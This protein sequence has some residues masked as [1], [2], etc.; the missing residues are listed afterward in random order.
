MKQIYQ[1]IVVGAGH[2][3]CEAALAL[4]RR[5]LSTLIFTL[6]LDNIALMSCNPAI[7]GTAKGHLVKEI[8]ALGGEMGKAADRTGIHFKVLNQSRGP[9]V[10]S[11]RAQCDRQLYRLDLKK[12]LEQEPHLA[13]RQGEVVEILTQGNQV[14][15]VSDHLGLVYEAPVVIL[16]TG[17]FLKG[18]IHVG[19]RSY[20][21]GR[22]GEFA[23]NSLSES[24][25]DLGFQLGRLKT[26][27]P[28]RLRRSTIDF[29]GTQEQRGDDPPRPFSYFTRE[30]TLPQVPCYLTYTN[31]KTHKIIRDNLHLSSLYGGRIKSRGARYCPSIEDKVVRFAEKERHPII[32]E[33]D[34]LET[35][36][37]YANGT[38]NSLPPE[39]QYELI[40]TIPGLEAAEIMRPAY[41]IEYDFIYPTQLLPTLES[42]PI[43]GLFAAGQI[44]GTSGY[45]EAAAQGL[46]A[47]INAGQKLLGLPPFILDRSQ[48][49]MAVLVD[50]LVTKGTAEPYRIFTSRA[51]YRL[52]LREDNAPYR[53]MELGHQLGLIPQ[54]G[55]RQMQEEQRK[56]QQEIQRLE[57]TFIKPT[58]ELNQKMREKGT[59]ELKE[60]ESLGQ[61]LRRPQLGYADIISLSPPPRELSAK[62]L[63]QV[64]IEVKYEGY[65]KRQQEEVERFRRLEEQTLPQDLDYTLIP[66]LSLEVRQK[67]NT[68]KPLSLG[69]AS[70]I[71]GITPAAVSVLMVYLKKTI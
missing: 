6:N 10:Q 65:I 33:P 41:A 30:I 7:G 63:Q 24:L 62:V 9:A 38:G 32:L 57:K 5:G 44:N 60:A 71:S 15:G 4:A 20:P 61:L 58:E 23:A 52:L 55:Y 1:V 50:D 70:R 36:E 49:Y 35:E 2:A 56:I 69:Q 42:K 68:F 19:D 39:V 12:T 25:T 48:A 59:A 34:G 45:E 31:E 64:E 21:A 16:T 8:D 11:S 28:M 51:E 27:T 66:G 18:L 54:E 53:L 47:G 43:K 22:A 37:I 17:T 14:A 26:G 40:H 67:L 29:T 3:G 13:I 46:W